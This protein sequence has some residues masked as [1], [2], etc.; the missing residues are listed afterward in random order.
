M[1]KAAV[2][3]LWTSSPELVATEV[4]QSVLGEGCGCNSR[5]RGIC[6]ASSLPHLWVC[7]Q[8]VHVFLVS[9]SLFL[10]CW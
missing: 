6:L 7:L 2:S 5:P 10:S 4:R 9:R 8:D 1:A 3:F